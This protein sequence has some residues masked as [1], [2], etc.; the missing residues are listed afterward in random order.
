MTT[1]PNAHAVK[2]NGDVIPPGRCAYDMGGSRLGT[3]W[4]FCGRPATIRCVIQHGGLDGDMRF[5]DYCLQ[6]Y[7]N[8]MRRTRYDV[9]LASDPIPTKEE[10]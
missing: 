6:H 5:E 8:A 9:V 3:T 10:S 4:H 1:T 7:R 2:P